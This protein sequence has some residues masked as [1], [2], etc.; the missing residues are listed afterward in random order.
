MEIN[1][2]TTTILSKV[3]LREAV[4]LF[5]PAFTLHV[6][7]ESPRFTFWAKRYASPLFT[8]RDYNTIHVTGIVA[9]LLFTIFVWRFPNPA[10][11]FVFFA[12][13]FA[14]SLFFNALFHAGATVVTREYCPGVITALTLYLPIF[15]FVLSVAWRENLLDLRKLILTL[16]VAGSFH[17]WEVGHNVFK[18]W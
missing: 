12:F 3:T 4:W 16:L 17:I 5:P 18:A 11:V 2:T 10:V 6:L 14:P 13:I 8:Q 1:S 15:F 9:S 7:E